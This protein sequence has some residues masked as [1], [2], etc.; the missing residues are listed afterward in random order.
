MSDTDRPINQPGAPGSNTGHGHVFPRPDGARA[1]C[2]GP[3]LC[4]SCRADAARKSADETAPIKRRVWLNDGEE[5]PQDV[6]V[7]DQ[8]GEIHWPGEDDEPGT[9]SSMHGFGPLVEI[10]LPSRSEFW[11]AVEAEQA[12]R[13]SGGDA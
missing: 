3:A 7:V 6:R 12:R 1:R 10:H 2:G 4:G 9:T 5:I 11:A 13:A 8:D